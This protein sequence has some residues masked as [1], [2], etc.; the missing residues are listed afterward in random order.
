MPRGQTAAN[1]SRKVQNPAIRD[2]A[3]PRR[4]LDNHNRQGRPRC[5]TPH[6][7]M[8][9]DPESAVKALSSRPLSMSTVCCDAEPATTAVGPIA[10]DGSPQQA[11]RRPHRHGSPGVVGTRRRTGGSAGGRPY[12]LCRESPLRL[13]GRE[14]DFDDQAAAGIRAC[15]DG[16]SGRLRFCSTQRCHRPREA[17]GR[18][19]AAASGPGAAAAASGSATSTGL[20]ACLRRVSMTRPPSTSAT[21]STTAVDRKLPPLTS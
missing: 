3:Y 10:K 14:G 5:R 15:V 7:G 8:R 17:P 13:A 21:A 2:S 1:A 20:S 4:V 6:P 19:E 12:R 18:C 11:P 9:A 16:R